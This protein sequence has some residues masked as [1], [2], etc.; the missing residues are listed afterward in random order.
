MGVAVLVR[1]AGCRAGLVRGPLLGVATAPPDRGMVP[2]KPS[3]RSQVVL[4]EALL[5]VASQQRVSGTMRGR[6]T[7][8]DATAGFVGGWWRSD[9]AIE[10]GIY[11]SH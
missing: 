9:T 8:V 2:T 4:S 10:A 5:P 11:N 3:S 6:A 7:R 1:A